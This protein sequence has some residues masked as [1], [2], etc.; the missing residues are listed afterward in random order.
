MDQPLQVYE[1]PLACV[2]RHAT[3]ISYQWHDTSRVLP[4]ATSRCF[5]HATSRFFPTSVSP[6]KHT[7]ARRKGLAALRPEEA[8]SRR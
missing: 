7:Q 2:V 8:A 4:H 3:G 1:L 6:I 5:G